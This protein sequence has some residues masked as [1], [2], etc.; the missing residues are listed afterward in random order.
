MGQAKFTESDLEGALI[1]RLIDLGYSYDVD[2]DNWM[3]NRKLDSFINDELL[4]ERLV[5]INPGVKI[6]VLEQAIADL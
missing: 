1:E 6:S 4:L 3:V 2:T 5:V